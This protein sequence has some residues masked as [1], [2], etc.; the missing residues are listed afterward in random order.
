MK[1]SPLFWLGVVFASYVLISN[2]CFTVDQRERAVLFQLGEIRGTDFTPGL[3]FKMPGL[4]SVQKFDGRIQT[5]DN[6]TENFITVEKKNVEVDFFVKWRISDTA[7]YYRATGGQEEVASDRLS[8]II[9]PGL[10]AQFGSRTIQQAV[11]TERDEIMSALMASAKD[12]VRELGVQLVDVRI[13]TI[14]QPK[15]V[16]GSAYDRMRAERLRTAADFRARG[17][18][19][20]ETI[21]AEA[22][23]SA[24]VTLA[25]AYREA[26]K[27]R[28]EGDAK[29]SEIYARAY[30]QDAEFYSFYRSLS[31]YRDT[32]G[33]QDVLVLEP[34]G[35]FFK[36]FKN[37]GK[38]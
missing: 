15:G 21:R 4:Q 8:A 3:H 9:N 35:E 36:Y 29:A 37:G 1:N 30:G 2:S 18:E 27:L 38:K 7:A 20:A 19:Q 16:S 28:G 33:Q 10:R 11:T 25:T 23:R 12:R 17:F 34:K 6:Q 26:E 32:I 13:K 31:V 24:Q 5:L 22:D 14:N